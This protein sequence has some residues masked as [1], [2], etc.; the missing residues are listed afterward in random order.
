[1]F[2]TLNSLGVFQG[3]GAARRH[4]D[5]L[6]V[7]YDT[8]LIELKLNKEH[9][10]SMIFKSIKKSGIYKGTSETSRLAFITNSIFNS[11]FR[12]CLSVVDLDLR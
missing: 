3:V 7:G 5:A 1:M 2:N 9:Q 4:V 6:R 10:V 8:R 12:H 11:K